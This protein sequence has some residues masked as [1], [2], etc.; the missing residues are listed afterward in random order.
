MITELHAYIHGVKKYMG[1]PGSPA[2][3]EG[4]RGRKRAWYTLT[5]HAQVFHRNLRIF[6]ILRFILPYIYVQ[7]RNTKDVI[8]QQWQC[9]VFLVLVA[10]LA[11]KTT[12]LEG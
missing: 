5:V 12:D 2:R 6:V 8:Y 3:T 11:L 10:V 4:G 1:P 9:L 7:M